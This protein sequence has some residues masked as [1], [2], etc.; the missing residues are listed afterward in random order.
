MVLSNQMTMSTAKYSQASCMGR[1][2]MHMLSPS[3]GITPQPAVGILWR[4]TLR[5]LLARAVSAVKRAGEKTTGSVDEV[6]L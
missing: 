3:V 6:P 2:F 4:Y 1:L 5:T